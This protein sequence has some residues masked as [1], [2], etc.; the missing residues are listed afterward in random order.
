MK[1]KF[2][3][4][5]V[6]NKLLDWANT[7]PSVLLPALLS[8]SLALQFTLSRMFLFFF[9]L[10]PSLTLLSLRLLIMP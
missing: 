10:T 3:S 9:S 1:K 6:N 4:E 5:E 2:E 8:R 7:D